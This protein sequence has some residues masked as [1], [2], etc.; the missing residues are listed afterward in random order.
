MAL[1]R[2]HHATAR[3]GM[4]SP[5][6][7]RWK[8]GG[9]GDETAMNGSD[10]LTDIA[11]LHN[12]VIPGV[13]DGSRS[14]E[15]SLESLRDFHEEGVARLAVTPHLYLQHLDAPGELNARMRGL[16]DAFAQL[17]EQAARTGLAPELHFAQEICAYDG[18]YMSRVVDDPEIGIGGTDYMLVEFGFHLEGDPDEVIDAVH[19]AGRRIVIAH[20]ERY[21]HPPGEDPL[22]TL[23]RW[24]DAGALLQVNLGSL[25]DSGSA[26][27]R[28]AAELGWSLLDEGLAH[29]LSSDHHCRS[30]PQIIHQAVHAMI[31]ERGG[32]TQADL[33]LR[34]NPNRIL[35]GL[36]PL[37]VE[38]LC[39]AVGGV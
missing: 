22:E 14:M 34:E 19:A 33:L 12:H 16:R 28:H 39:G 25:F 3:R 13:D 9:M 7:R 24:R 1:E 18:R 36:A 32:V 2:I 23:R 35:D 8:T 26:Y 30:R 20:P 38:G 10:R 17:E 5:A 11:D 27:G 4:G 29:L 31:S 21:N 37:P 15:E 6:A